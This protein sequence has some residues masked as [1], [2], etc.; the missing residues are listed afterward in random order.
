MSA[1]MM[2]CMFPRYCP[3]ILFSSSL[4]LLVDVDVVFKDVHNTDGL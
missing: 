3:P 1:R 2:H 4:L